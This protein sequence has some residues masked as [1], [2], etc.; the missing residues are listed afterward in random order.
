MFA[1]VGQEEG[2][3]TVRN[4]HGK[5]HSLILMFASLKNRYKSHQLPKLLFPF[6]REI[7]EPTMTMRAPRAQA[8]SPL[9]QNIVL[10]QVS[11]AMYPQRDLN[12]DLKY[13]NYYFG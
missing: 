3:K 7:P 13:R 6:Q 5:S 2:R 4:G 10:L 8:L 1:G 9:Y 12:Q 11:T